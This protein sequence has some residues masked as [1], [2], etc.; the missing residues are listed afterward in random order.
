MKR[1]ALLCIAG[2]LMAGCAPV[3]YQWGHYES[4]LYTYYKSP[5]SESDFIEA[6]GEDLADAEAKN[7]VPPGLFAEY[8]FLLLKQGKHDEAR[9][10]FL[11]EQA[12]W[13]ESGAFMEVL[14]KGGVANPAGNAQA[15]AGSLQAVGSASR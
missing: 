11:K 13:P 6:L 3:Q 2:L 10:Y 9:Q 1:I 5:A 15:S 7:L 4:G 8:G 14:L 12:K